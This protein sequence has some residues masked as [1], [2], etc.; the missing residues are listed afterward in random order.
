MIPSYQV[1]RVFG[2]LARPRAIARR[3]PAAPSKTEGQGDREL[4][5]AR[6][7]E[8]DKGE[9]L[10]VLIENDPV[11]SER[12]TAVLA[13][14]GF[15]VKVIPDG[16]DLLMGPQQFPVL[17]ILCIDPKRLGWAIC[18]KIKKTVQY[19]DVPMIVTSAEA[20]DKD[21]DDH[22]K[23]PRTRAEAYLHKPFSVEVLLG[24]IDELV[25]LEEAESAE[26]IDETAIEEISVDDAVIEEEAPA[27]PSGPT[28]ALRANAV[29]AATAGR[30]TPTATPVLTAAPAA[31]ATGSIS[32]P[33]AA[34]AVARSLIATPWRLIS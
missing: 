27:V 1:S 18:N 10:L 33:A 16:N 9:R 30:A 3:A 20:T 12:I 7:M 19:R 24:R 34:P 31:A 26:P 29:T 25:G 28:L 14:Y 13:T 11:L 5:Y 23:L 22:R 15:R 8:K 17:I 4:W 2:S 6:D 21:F 32:R